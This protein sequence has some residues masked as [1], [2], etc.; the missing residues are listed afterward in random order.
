MLE[1]VDQSNPELLRFRCN[2][3][4][5]VGISTKNRAND[6]PGYFWV[7]TPRGPTPGRWAQHDCEPEAVPAPTPKKRGKAA[8]P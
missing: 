3:C 8:A 4:G 2:I 5:V 1:L 7:A 6:E